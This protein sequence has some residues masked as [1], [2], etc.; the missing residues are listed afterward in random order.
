MDKPV[1]DL[2]PLRKALGCLA[3]AL[4]LWH[5]QPP[6][7]VLKP[8]LRPAVIQ[9]FEFSYELSLRS[10]QRVLIERAGS[11]DRVT[12]LS[13]NDL[14]RSAADA[15][16]PVDP[17]M[18]RLARTAQCHRPCLRRGQGRAGGARCRSLL[19]RRPSIAGG[20]GGS[21]VTVAARKLPASEPTGLALSSAQRVLVRQLI[22]DVLPG[23]QVAV[24]GSRATGRARPFSDL[25]L[26]LI[27]P[28]R[29]TWAERADLRDAFEASSLPFRVDLVEVAALAEGMRPRVL[30]EA[31][32]LPLSI[33]RSGALGQRLPS[34]GIRQQAP[35]QHVL[36]T[37]DGCLGHADLV[38]LVLVGLD[39]SHQRFA[40]ASLWCAFVSLENALKQHKRRLQFVVSAN[41]RQRHGPVPLRIRRP[42]SEPSSVNPAS[43]ST[44]LPAR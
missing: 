10:L 44:P 26:L 7:S 27:D 3:E 40:L 9:S 22:D 30:A 16:L 39:P 29:L 2:A 8:H 34:F 28:P 11:A 20:A 13:F 36:Q 38:L 23:A 1:I 31:V 35:S 37:G 21:V 12:D 32:P 15:G 33:G 14:L 24:S 17:V 43:P 42:T 18:A 4:M 41:G 6:G 19:H 5:A 25:D